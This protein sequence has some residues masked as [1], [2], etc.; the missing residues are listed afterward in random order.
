MSPPIGFVLLSHRAPR[1]LQ[2]LIDTLNRMFDRPPIVCHHDFSQCALST[3]AFSSNVSFV[4]PHVKT[5][6][7]TFSLIEATVRAIGQLHD[8]ANRPEWYVLLSAADYPI[9]PTAQIISDLQSA[10]CDAFMQCYRV[11]PRL[12][13]AWH[14][15]RHDRYCTIGITLPS[16][17]RH[18]QR[19]RRR[20]VLLRKS[21]LAERRLPFSPQLHCYAGSQWFTANRRA[22]ERILEFHATPNPLAAH[23]RRV[24]V[25]D[26]SYFQTIL[27]NAADITICNDN[28]RY[29]DWSAGGTSPKTLTVEDLPALQQSNAHFARK[30]DSTVDSAVLDV[31]DRL[32]QDPLTSAPQGRRHD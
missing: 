14:R 31:L 2:R 11:R 3:R 10:Q 20:L 24:L 28:L 18:R 30:F 26:E 9:K 4:Q 17:N 21:A 15:T 19:T 16:V 5:R 29:M 13:S 23:Y 8:S 25:P 1:Q 7:G 6:W 12:D 32:T 27:G 22:V